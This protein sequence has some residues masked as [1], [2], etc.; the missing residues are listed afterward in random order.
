MKTK[1]RL[2]RGSVALLALVAVTVAAVLVA[3]AAAGTIRGTPRSDTMRGT[4]AADKLYG[5]AGND[6]LYG[7]GGNDYLNGGP[8][9][10]LVS[11]GPGADTLVCGPGRD[12]AI[13]DGSDKIAADCEAVRGV[14]KPSI[15]GCERFAGRGQ[16]RVARRD[17]HRG[18]GEGKSAAGHGRVCNRRR[19][20]DR[21]E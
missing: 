4:A 8:G 17:L 20:G 19:D 18:P 7:L 14:P 3:S 21:R 15:S 11:G 10:D 5:N 12:A 2:R 9:N 6:R 16:R 1:E 13:A